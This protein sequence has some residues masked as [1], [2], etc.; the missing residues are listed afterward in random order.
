[1]YNRHMKR[2]PSVKGRSKLSDSSDAGDQYPSATLDPSPSTRRK[3]L[4][5]TDP[6]APNGQWAEWDDADPEFVGPQP[7]R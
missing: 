3:R 4:D 2:P 6:A 5:T 1:M 7:R